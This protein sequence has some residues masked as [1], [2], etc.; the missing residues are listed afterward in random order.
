MTKPDSTIDLLG[1]LE[2]IDLLGNKPIDAIK[3]P[4]TSPEGEEEDETKNATS[5]PSPTK[6]SKQ[7]KT[8]QASP[9]Q[10]PDE[11]EEEDE[12]NPDPSRN[13]PPAEPSTIDEIRERLGYEVEGDFSNDVDGVVNLI[14]QTLPKAAEQ[15]V[16][17]MLDEYPEARDLI[18]HLAAGYSVDSWKQQQESTNILNLEVSAEDEDLQTAI[19]QEQL[20]NSGIPESQIPDIIESMKTKGTLFAASKEALKRRQQEVQSG[21][22]RQQEQEKAQRLQQEQEAKKQ[23][24]S[25]RQTVFNGKVGEINIPQSK[26]GAF[27]D[28]LSKPIKDKDGSMTTLKAQKAA[29]MTMEQQ[30]MLEYMIFSDFKITPGKTST[31]KSLESLANANNGRQNRMFNNSKDGRGDYGSGELSG[32]DGTNLKSF[33]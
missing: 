32:L 3:D 17:Q 8:P 12:D 6:Q 20:S 18:N 5:T 24:D 11:D 9:G 26:Q 16:T 21:I 4:D 14:Q 30:L 13:T 28:Y 31:S 1:S 22:M 2:M 27:W 7:T 10:N 29:S 23:W 19:M 15:M 25:I 33:F